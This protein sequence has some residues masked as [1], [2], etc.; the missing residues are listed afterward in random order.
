MNDQT[1]TK[2]LN[3]VTSVERVKSLTSGDLNDLCDATEAAIKGG[4]GFGWVNLPP[5]DVLERY[6]QG[7]MTIPARILFVARLD[8]VICGTCQLVKPPAN[9][10]AQ[11]FSL[12][13]TTNF[14]APWARGHGLAKML[15][16]EA[17]KAALQDGYS[18]INL[19]VRETMNRAIETYESMG[20]VRFGTHPQYAKVNG[21]II[22][23]YYYYKVID[24][25]AG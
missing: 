10:E 12:H 17:E 19:D 11:S 24:L 14:V 7:V 18:V 5:R 3:P 22:K 4:G 25:Q 23:G 9:N 8:G 21:E 2:P 20:Y 16:Q 6:W 1:K 13:L 15:L